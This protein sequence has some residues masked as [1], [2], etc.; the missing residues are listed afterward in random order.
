MLKDLKTDT[1]VS[2]SGRTAHCSLF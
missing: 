1:A 2:I